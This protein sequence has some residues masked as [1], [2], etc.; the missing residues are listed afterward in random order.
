VVALWVD[1]LEQHAALD[2]VFGL[3]PGA[4]GVLESELARAIEDADRA[5]LVSDGA[6]ITGFCAAQVQR[7]PTLVAESHRVEITEIVVATGARRRGHGR[8]LA[9]AALAWARERGASRIE[10]RVAARNGRCCRTRPA[11]R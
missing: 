1:L 8:A 5:L 9:E 7:G 4:A 2:P 3:R 10:V 6:E 11:P